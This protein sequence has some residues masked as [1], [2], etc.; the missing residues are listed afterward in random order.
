MP[1]NTE[2]PAIR[3][4][5]DPHVSV[6]KYMDL[7]KYVSMLE[8]KG[9]YFS[10]LD[11]LNDPFEGTPTKP[12][13]ERRKRLFPG[14][15]NTHRGRKQ[16]YVSCWHMNEIESEAMWRLYAD[17][18]Y[19]VAIKT[20]YYK[21]A[22]ALPTNFDPALHI[23]P[24]LGEIKYIDFEVNDPP[25]DNGFH[26][27]MQKRR[28]FEHERECRAVLWRVGSQSQRA[29]PIDDS[30]LLDKNP[31]GIDVDLR[32]DELI[33]SVFVSPLAPAWFAETVA[34]LTETYKYSFPVHKS[35]LLAKPYL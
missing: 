18:G 5:K 15:E 24:F 7:A 32:L 8:K 19:A 1:A 9:L 30:A 3:Q 10:R 20:T 13:Y 21:L 12:T 28:A 23:G 35:A 29:P 31:D 33:E 27:L 16:N 6:W 17:S 11:A 34:K 26:A 14:N 22:Q 2:H 25:T 4:P